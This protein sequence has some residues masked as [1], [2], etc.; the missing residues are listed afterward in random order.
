MNWRGNGFSLSLKLSKFSSNALD[1]LSV[2]R[3][4][5]LSTH[6]YELLIEN[7]SIPNFIRSEIQRITSNAPLT[8]WFRLILTNQLLTK[9]WDNLSQLKKLQDHQNIQ[10]L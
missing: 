3:R 4:T 2:I 10:R 9:W 7:L 1:S 6:F 5:E 8:P